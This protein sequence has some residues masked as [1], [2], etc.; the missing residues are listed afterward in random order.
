MRYKIRGY[1]I[2]SEN[3]AKPFTQA[4]SNVLKW[5]Q[6]QSHVKRILDFGCGKLRYAGTL[7]EKCD[8][9]SLV[10]SEVQ[11]WRKQM[12]HKRLATVKEYALEKWPHSDVCSLED[13][14]IK[15]HSVKYDLI[16]CANVVSAIPS[17]SI[18]NKTLKLLLSCLKSE[19]RLFIVNQFKNSYFSKAI[20]AKQTIQHLDGY[21]L[22]CGP[23][24]YYYG[25]LPAAK[26]SH[27]LNG[28]GFKISSK[29]E[30]GQS[31]F[32]VAEKGASNV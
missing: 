2:R 14:G 13:F 10:D 29:W 11:I 21:L 27:I 5:I 6:E 26:M 12:I 32:V 1:E 17:K 8:Q 25:I 24:A 9:L 30:K 31:S 22:P 4:S 28:C 7:A 15:N 16:F 19:G 18:R 20:K 23:K 3:A